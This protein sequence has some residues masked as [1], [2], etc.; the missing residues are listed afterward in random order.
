M[1]KAWIIT[2]GKTGAEVQSKG[3]CEALNAEYSL[4]SIRPSIPW[5][6]LAPRGPVMPSDRSDRPTSFIQSPLPD[7]AFAASRLA[8]PYLQEIKKA[9]QGYT[10]T[11]ALLDPRI[12]SQVADLVW[13]P[14][15]DKLHGSNV[16][17][18][19][20]SP[21]P[22]SPDKLLA[23]RGAA[24]DILDALPFPRVM[25]SLGGPNG[26]YKFTPNA[27][28]RLV[29]AVQD[30]A[31]L[32]ASFLITASRRTPRSLYEYI[33]V[34]TRGRP[35]LLWDGGAGDNPYLRFLANADYYIV[36]AD[37]VNMTGEACAT[38]RPVYVFMPDGKGGK[39][40][41]FHKALRAYGATRILPDQIDTLEDWSYEPLDSAYFIATE[42]EKRIANK[43]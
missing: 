9:S 27:I 13:V 41:V 1:R 3:V 38:G 10:F 29:N 12:G 16:I 23:M 8:I 36:T 15:H 42:I 30:M 35:R 5:K 32:G 40:E 14:H 18:S 24:S 19:I 37:S 28:N 11:V 25:V 2:D 7:L 39:F 26:S 6:W 34:A 17:T 33:D 21:H 20:T 22:H 43:S 31:T 4:K